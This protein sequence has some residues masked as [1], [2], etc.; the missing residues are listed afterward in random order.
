MHVKAFL[1]CAL[2]NGRVVSLLF[3]FYPAS[4]IQVDIFERTPVNG[5]G[6]TEVCPEAGIIQMFK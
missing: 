3:H 6:M 4:L 5:Y 2:T 1:L